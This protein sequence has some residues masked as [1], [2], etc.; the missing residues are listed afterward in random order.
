MSRIIIL[1]LFQVTSHESI[2]RTVARAKLLAHLLSMPIQLK[3]LRIPEFR[4][5]LHVIKYVSI[6]ICL[7]NFLSTG[8]LSNKKYLLLLPYEWTKACESMFFYNIT[9]VIL[10]ILFIGIRWSKTKCIEYSSI[11]WSSHSKLSPW[12]K[13]INS[14]WQKPCTFS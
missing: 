14:Y 7:T 11:C 12:F 8:N 5:L 6:F 1:F 10:F 2:D 4:W 9:Y 3:H 13:R